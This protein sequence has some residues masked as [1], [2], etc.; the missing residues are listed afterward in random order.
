MGHVNGEDMTMSTYRDLFEGERALG[1]ERAGGVVQIRDEQVTWYAEEEDFDAACEW[2]KGETIVPVSQAYDR[3]C[4]NCPGEV[5][6]G[7][8]EKCL[9]L[10]ARFA[11]GRH[12]LS[13]ERGRED[14][15]EYVFGGD[16]EL[17]TFACMIID[18][19]ADADE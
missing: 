4:Q 7:R 3:F 12:D 11:H 16:R 14:A 6:G 1:V 10:E 9:R 8:G 2:A 13:S 5:A 18:A 15:L 19:G 17:L